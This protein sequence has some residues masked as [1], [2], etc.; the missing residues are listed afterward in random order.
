MTQK[1]YQPVNFTILTSIYNTSKEEKTIT[2]R[3]NW[4][5]CNNQRASD[6]EMELLRI[7]LQGDI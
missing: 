2:I 7:F 6:K 4:P 5:L 1:F 3:Q